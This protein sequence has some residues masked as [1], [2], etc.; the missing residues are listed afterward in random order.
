[1]KVWYREIYSIPHIILGVRSWSGQEGLLDCTWRLFSSS[2]RAWGEA[3]W[4]TTWISRKCFVTG[5]KSL[6]L[7]LSLM[8][9]TL[10]I[11][12]ESELCI[13]IS[14]YGKLRHKCRVKRA[15]RGFFIREQSMSPSSITQNANK[16]RNEAS[17][18]SMLRTLWKMEVH[19]K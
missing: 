10:K 5:L 2:C 4:V 13:R 17:E 15:N 7:N 9:D 1:M 14:D 8:E 11:Q 16:R 19:D 6:S 18:F 3:D 12:E